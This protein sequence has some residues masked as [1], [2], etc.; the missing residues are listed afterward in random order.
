MFSKL[1][2]GLLGSLILVLTLRSFQTRTALVITVAIFTASIGFFTII[3]RYDYGTYK[4]AETGWVPTITLCAVAAAQRRDW[5]RSL[6]LLFAVLLVAASVIRII[7]FDQWTTVKSMDQFS[8]LGDR[9]PKDQMIAVSISDPLSFEW[10]SYYLRDHK[11]TIRSGSLPYYPS[12]DPTQEPYASRLKSAN[13]I[14]TDVVAPSLGDPI[15]SNSRYF[16][17][18]ATPPKRQVDLP[19]K[20]EADAVSSPTITQSGAK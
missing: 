8:V 10:A 13:T 6:T 11:T 3:Q 15:W 9:L 2:I 4:I 19:I 7:R 12:P 17:Y 1:A 16:V 5:K 18:S 20:S 14:V